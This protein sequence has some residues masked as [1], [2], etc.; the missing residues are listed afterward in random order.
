MSTDALQAALDF[1]PDDLVA[2]RA[3]RLSPSQQS[4][5]SK[6]QG[7]GRIFTIVMAVVAVVAIVVI[8]ATVLPGLLAPQPASSSAVPPGIIVAVIVVVAA[9]MALSLLRTRRGL[10]RMTGP[11][12][13]VEGVAKTRARE[14]ED[15][16]MGGLATFRVRVGNVT[17]P[18]FGA[19]QVG[20]FEDGKTYRAYYVK[21]TLPVIV[22][23]EAV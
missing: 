21:T 5:M 6:S 12:L 22:S 11:V 4:R 8:A 1:T 20:A 7:R 16:T 19:A 3:G 2:N 14:F 17:F 23:A 18:V 9:L 10:G 15:E 13:S